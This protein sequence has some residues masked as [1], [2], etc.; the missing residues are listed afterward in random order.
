M[1]LIANLQ[2]GLETAV[3]PW[4][5]FYCLVGTLLGT[6]IGVLPGVGPLATIAMLLPITMTLPPTASLIMLAGIYYGA[7]YGGSTTAILVNLPGEP[8]SAV[9]ALDGYQMARQGRAGPALAIAAIGSFVAGTVATLVI[10]LFA[11]P[12]TSV[13]LRFGSP[14]Y[15]SLIILGFIA[16]VA[17]SH[18]S[19]LK[20]LAMIVLGIGFG[21]VGT[22]L[23]TGATRLTFGIPELAD[24]IDMVSVSVAMF[25]IAE[26]FRNLE[27]ERD[28]ELHAKTINTLLP[29]RDD[30]RRSAGPIARGTVL[31]T[32]LGILPGG[33]AV[34][35]SFASYA[36]EKKLSSEPSR[37]GKGAIE[38]V[39]GPEA[40]NNA[41][42]QTSFIPMLTLGIPSNGIMAL[43]IGAMIMQGLVPGPSVALQKPDVFWGLI[44]SMWVG[45]LMLLVLN[46]PLLG[47][48]VRLLTIP[49]RALFPA[50]VVFC[51]IG[52]Y[53]VSANVADLYALA[54]FAVLG[55]A[56]S[57]V[58]CEPTPFILG[59]VLGPMLEEHLRRAMIL[60]DGSPMI[61]LQHPISAAFL[62]L[63]AIALVLVAYPSL[64]RRRNEV[65]A[66]D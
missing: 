19:I 33:G 47:L 28:R 3:S 24:G 6:L 40:A 54:A 7:Q 59:F 12:L 50:I 13:A 21:A 23:Y 10:C 45:N 51:I 8:S 35:S 30:V 22:D 56:L 57:R 53:S 55:Y 43:M 61:F 16:A 48:W 4:N 34:L 27:V 18:G 9:T 20:A 36:L 62:A 64:S 52:A 60:G 66:E 15:F 1:D 37:F 38:A 46:L 5:L 41:G 63:A 17:L 26:I 11:P 14:E 44:V 25:G 31:G 58:G 42:A 65:F 2:V 32:L 29:S 49:Y 39:A